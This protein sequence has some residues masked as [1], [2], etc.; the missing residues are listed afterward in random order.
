[1]RRPLEPLVVAARRARDDGAVDE[2]PQRRLLR[3]PAAD[4]EVDEAARDREVGRGELAD[5]A[6]VAEE[7]VHEPLAEEAAHRLLI[8][9]RAVR[10]TAAER[11]PLRLPRAPVVA[12]EV[13]EHDRRARRLL[14]RLDAAAGDQLGRAGRAARRVAD[15]EFTARTEEL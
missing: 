7:G 13:G 6:V 11:G 5:E 15:F 2:E 12:L 8:L 1:E 14:R 3:A 4:Q 9:L 10:G